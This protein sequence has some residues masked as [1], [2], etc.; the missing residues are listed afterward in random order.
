MK[1]FLL[2]TSALSGLALAESAIPSAFA[3][4]RYQETLLASPFALATPEEK[5]VEEKPD[6]PL[7]NLVVAGMGKL[8]N[9]ENF[10]I[11]QRIGDERSMRFEG[12]KPNAD[13]IAVKQV[14]W[15]EKWRQSTV[16]MT[17]GSEE[18]AVEFNQSA[19]AAAPPAQP[20]IPGTSSRA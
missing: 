5:K 20:C 1:V 17:H 7:N 2:V 8:D 9:G 18:K 16:V 11:V 14:K 4:E 15:A 6:S 19:V 3:R 10:V 13:G 12:N